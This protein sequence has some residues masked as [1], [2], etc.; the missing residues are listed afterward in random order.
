M[1][2]APQS[3]TEALLHNVRL[4]RIILFV[5]PFLIYCNTLGHEFVLDDGIVITE[6]IYVQ[7]GLE[8][9][10]DIL[11]KDSFRGFFQKEGKEKLVA[12]GRYRPLSLM[13]FA[14]TVQLF[15]TS[16]VV[17]HLLAVLMYAVLG[18]IMYWALQKLLVVRWSA[19]S[20]PFAFFSCMIF[21]AHPVHTECVANVKGIDETL[22]LLFSLASL[23]FF[24]NYIDHQKVREAVLAGLMCCLALLA[25]E[26]SVSYLLLIPA[27]AFLFRTIQWRNLI[28]PCLFLFLAA[29]LFLVLRVNSLGWNPFSK[30][31]TE[32]MNNPFMK[33]VDGQKVEMNFLERWS[34]ITYCLYEYLRLLIWPHPLTHDYY[35]KHIPVLGLASWKSLFA[36]GAYTLMIAMAFLQIKRVKEISFAILAYLLPLFLVSNILFPVGTNMGERFLFMPTM[37]FVLAVV[38]GFQRL[39]G[40]KWNRVVYYCLPLILV[41]SVLTILRNPAWS[42]N[43]NLF[44]T[45]A[46]VSINSA[47]IHNG[48][49]GVLMEKLTGLKDTAA[50]RNILQKSRVELEKALAIHPAYMEAHLQMGNVLFHEKNYELAIERYNL[51]LKNIPEDEDA[52]NNLQL[53]LR[54]RGRQL[55]EAGAFSKAK[56][57]IQKAL[58]MKP[59]DA[60]SVLLMGIAEGSSG[61]GQAAIDWFLKAIELNPKNPQAFL[62]LGIAYQNAGQQQRADSL[63][64]IAQAMDAGII[65]RNGLE[66]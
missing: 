56:D 18:L 36:M 1:H 39:S 49:A 53:A 63:F 40:G 9:I 5:F 25:K 43:E 11:S 48:I 12:G 34:I 8:G 54:E 46:K 33:L 2:Q 60:E 20:L 27:S 51:I 58:G 57:Y 26:N 44:T 4:H 17:F 23:G 42:D 10:P 16:A 66:K 45:D 13:V 64:Q 7:N 29:T 37:G 3:A 24:L 65:K 19:N 30:L 6:N 28:V 41:Y 14:L 62:N 50:I 59:S 31:S 61:N 38:Y 47:K 15:G 35:P 21:L 52:F 22:A 32:L 55:G